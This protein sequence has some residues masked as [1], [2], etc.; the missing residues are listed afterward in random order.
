MVKTTDSRHPLQPSPAPF[1]QGVEV[2][3]QANTKV[4]YWHRDLQRNH[5]RE[6]SG[7]QLV[8]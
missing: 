7:A 3:T 4:I 1:N 8:T 5:L 6:P 2:G